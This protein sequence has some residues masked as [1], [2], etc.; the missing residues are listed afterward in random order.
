MQL[1][2]V[3]HNRNVIYSGFYTPFAFHIALALPP[4]LFE[5]PRLTFSALVMQMRLS[6]LCPTITFILGAVVLPTVHSTLDIVIH[7][8]QLG[9]IIY[10]ITRPVSSLTSGLMRLHDTHP[11][12]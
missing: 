7:Q 5:I 9:D 8:Q 4:G 6:Y 11:L 3:W 12:I 1:L 10:G 2:Y